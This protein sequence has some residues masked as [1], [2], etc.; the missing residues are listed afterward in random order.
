MCG[1]GYMVENRNDKQKLTTKRVR[2]LSCGST[3]DYP[4]YPGRI[5]RT[6]KWVLEKIGSPLKFT[7]TTKKGS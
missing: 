1:Q 3:K 6:N 7:D 4:W 2:P 5:K